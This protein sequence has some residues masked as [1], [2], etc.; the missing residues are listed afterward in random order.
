MS[1]FGEDSALEPSER[2][3]NLY[4]FPGAVRTYLEWLAKHERR[5]LARESS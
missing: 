3:R 4:K 5:E 1:A 2:M